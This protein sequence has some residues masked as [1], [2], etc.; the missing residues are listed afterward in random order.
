MT[1]PTQSFFCQHG[2]DGICA[3]CMREKVPTTPT[4]TPTPIEAERIWLYRDQ[5]HYAVPSSRK[6]DNRPSTEYIR[7]DV[8]QRELT[9]A[10][11]ELERERL[12]HAAC[13]AIA[14]G[15]PSDVMEEYRTDSVMAVIQLVEQN[16][17]IQKLLNIYRGAATTA[18]ECEEHTDVVAPHCPVCLNNEIE[19]VKRERD[20]ARAEV[21]VLIR[22]IEGKGLA[23]GELQT[24]KNLLDI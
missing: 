7:A 9:A 20:E 4:Q 3:F 24:L 19:H 21:S 2:P 10:T 16:A 14:R 12:C 22:H 1:A 23:V 6:P 5:F 13:G 15:A 18:V 8:A 11:A 17:A